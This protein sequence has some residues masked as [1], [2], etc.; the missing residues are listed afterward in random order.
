MAL[1]RKGADER[2]GGDPRRRTARPF[3]VLALDPGGT[4]GWAYAEWMPDYPTD[5]P[6][7]Q[8]INLSQ[9]TFGTGQIGPDEHHEELWRLLNSFSQQWSFG[10]PLHIVYESFEFRQHINKNQAKA[11]VELISKEY[12][13]LI[14]LFYNLYNN[15]EWPL[16]LTAHTASAAKT[17]VP[18]KGPQANVKLRQLGLYQT[19]QVHANDA[20]RHLLR[21]LVVGLR[22]RE[23]ITDKWLASSGE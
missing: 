8:L 3:R 13:G 15:E 9:I 1:R 22:I 12:I 14:K 10:P 21:Y 11:K 19:G 2:P 17:F 16:T 5:D 18:D 4:T 23:P 7:P 6:L 20:L